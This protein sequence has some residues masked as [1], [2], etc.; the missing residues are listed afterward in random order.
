MTE[1]LMPS[2][3]IVKHNENTLCDSKPKEY[4]DYNITAVNME[5]TYNIEIYK[6]DVC[7]KS[8]ECDSALNKHKRKAHV[9]NNGL[10]CFL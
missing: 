9:L 10:C 3:K 5:D 6:C 7:E 4:L 8:F 1:E 2:D